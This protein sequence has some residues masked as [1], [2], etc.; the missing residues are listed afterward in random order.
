MIWQLKLR[1]LTVWDLNCVSL[2]TVIV[3]WAVFFSELYSSLNYVLLWAL[4]FSEPCS[5]LNCVLLWTIFFSEL[6]SSL[7]C[8]LLWALFFSELWFLW[9]LIFTYYTSTLT[10]K[11]TQP[12]TGEQGSCRDGNASAPLRDGRGE[13]GAATGNL[14]F[15]STLVQL[16]SRLQLQSLVQIQSLVQLQSLLWFVVWVTEFLFLQIICFVLFHYPIIINI[17]ATPAGRE[18]EGTASDRG[19]WPAIQVTGIYLSVMRN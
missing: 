1:T 10:L 3:Y 9:P 7:N 14:T 6:Y 4:V 8:V 13:T 15:T 2:C 11:Q 17:S 12:P 19:R 5:S 16:Q 18:R